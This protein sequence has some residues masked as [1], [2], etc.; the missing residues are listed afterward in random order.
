V[1]F[2]TVASRTVLGGKAE[3]LLEQFDYFSPRRMTSKDFDRG[4]RN[5]EVA[6]QRIY[7]R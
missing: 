5:A 3:R 1:D 7:E 6:R 4:F 2:R